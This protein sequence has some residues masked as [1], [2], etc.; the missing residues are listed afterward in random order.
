MWIPLA[1][2][3]VLSVVGGFIN[4]PF[5]GWERFHHFLEPSVGAFEAHHGVPVAMGL[6]I[7]AAIGV[8][9]V[10]AAYILYSKHRDTGELAPEVEK[11]QNPV[12]RGSINLWGVDRALYDFF[13][14]GGGKFA[15]VVWKWID[16]GIVDGAVKFMAFMTGLFS[17][18]FRRAQTGYVRNYALLMLVGVVAVVGGLLWGKFGR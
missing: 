15:T 6:I 4:L 14:T 11:L 2:L 10:M 13:V 16:A 3:A 1:I 17:E 5:P 18:V 7:G 8:A 9:G 12:Y